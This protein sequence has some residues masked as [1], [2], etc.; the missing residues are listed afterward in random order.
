M[1][2][3][4]ISIS[5]K[6]RKESAKIWSTDAMVISNLDD[7]LAIGEKDAEEKR[8]IT[9]SSSTSIGLLATTQTMTSH[10]T[11]PNRSSKS[12]NEKLFFWKMLCSKQRNDWTR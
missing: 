1:E 12:L 4:Q 9:K 8:K 7:E 11:T 2:K 6:M 3:K 10:T 5:Q